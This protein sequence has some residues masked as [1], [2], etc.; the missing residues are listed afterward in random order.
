MCEH[1]IHWQQDLILSGKVTSF[2]SWKLPDFTLEEDLTQKVF[3]DT[4]IV[5]LPVKELGAQSAEHMLL[6]P[7]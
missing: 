2:F 5:Y 4:F 6:D 3:I 1:C 7:S